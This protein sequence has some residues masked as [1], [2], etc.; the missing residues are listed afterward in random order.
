MFYNTDMKLSAYARHVGVSYRTAFRW[1]KSGKIKGRQMDTGTI[2]ITESIDEPGISQHLAKVAIYTRVS[3]AENKDN[4]ESQAKRLQDYC[5][6]KGYPVAMLVKEIGSGVNDTRPK[7]LKLLNDPAVTLIVVEHNDRLTRF[8]YNYIEQLLK[9]QNRKEDLVQ[10]LVSSV[11][12]FCA[13]LSC[14][15]RSN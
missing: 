9:M 12:S 6:A 4:L 8:G 10:D 5:A 15:R 1:F 11:T 3:A 14:Q 13:R 2:I 7:L